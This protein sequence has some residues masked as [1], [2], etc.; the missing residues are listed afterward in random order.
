MFL[1]LYLMV[2]DLSQEKLSFNSTKSNVRAEICAW[3]ICSPH[4]KHSELVARAA[5]QWITN[6]DRAVL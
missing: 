6:N 4:N 1:L 3:V 2:L 5:L